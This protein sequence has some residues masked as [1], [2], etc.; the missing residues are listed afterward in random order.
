MADNE[1]AERSIPRVSAKVVSKTATDRSLPE[2]F[3]DEVKGLVGESDRAYR[4]ITKLVIT[5]TQE[6]LKKLGKAK[7]PIREGLR[8]FIV[9]LL[10]VQFV[11]LAIILF[12]N[13]VWNLQISDFVINTYTVSVFAETLAGLII[14]IKFSF[15]SEE[16]TKLIQILNSV[17]ERFQKYDG[18]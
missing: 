8:D 5:I 3:D 16:E 18:K 17:V 14:M 11:V 2:Q 13:R 7:Q 9:A 6:E 10:S 12:T 15:N 4:E 1:P